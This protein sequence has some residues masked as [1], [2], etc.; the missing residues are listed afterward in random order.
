MPGLDL[1]PPQDENL[2]S[3]TSRSRITEELIYI[4]AIDIGT[5]STHL[6]IAEVDPV[7]KTFSI[8]LAEKSTT[9]LGERDSL[10]GSLTDVAINRGIEVLK[11]FKDLAESYKVETILTAATSA[12]REAPN[13]KIFLEQVKSEV[14]LDIEII[15]GTEEA[16]LIYLGVISGMEFGD[17]PHILIDIGGGSTELILADDDD[18]RALTSTKVGAVRLKRDFLNSKTISKQRVE[19]LKTFIEGSLEPSVDKILHRLNPSKKPVIVATSGTAMAIGSMIISE[20]SGP[21]LK[22]QGYRISK[23]KLDQVIHKILKMSPQEIEKFTSLSKRR[24]EIIIP[25][26]LILQ[27]SIEMLGIDEIVLSER[28]LREGL[29]VNWML[30]NGF[31]QDRLSLQGNIR[32]RTVLHQ[33]KRFAVNTH[34]AKRVAKI[35]LRIYDS[36]YGSLHEDQGDGRDLLWAASMLHACGQHIN[37]SGYHKHSWYL[38]RHGELLGYSHLEHL[39][40]AGIAR[41]HRKNFPKKRHEAWQCLENRHNRKIVYEMSIILR[42]AASL[43]R[44][45]EPAIESIEVNVDTSGILLRLVPVKIDQN[46]GLE[47]WSLKNALMMIKDYVKVPINIQVD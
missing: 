43:D 1:G 10:T 5:N 14:N 12:V 45:P 29:V 31:L 41:Y 46:I 32:K 26:A 8:K 19:F 38:I 7:L 47:Q 20:E 28:A 21:K 6:L 3:K 9:R 15:S 17:K 25:G 34:R 36:T 44:R 37:L 18:S 33:A 16:R 40:V 11:S 39:M 30:R 27:T 4:A 24:S 23:T 22:L 42:L 13:G 2:F 35:A